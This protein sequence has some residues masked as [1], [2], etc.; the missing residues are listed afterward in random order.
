MKTL[1]GKV[2]VVTGGAGGIGRATALRLAA[3]GCDVAIADVNEAGMDETA[4]EVRAR[5]KRASVHRVDVSKEDEM[6]RLVDDVH[7]AHGRVHVVVNNAGVAVSQTVAEHDLADFEWVV[8]INFWGV[9]YGSKLFLPRLVE[10]GEGHIVNISSVFGLIGLPTQSAYCATKFAVRGF[11][12][13]LRA[14]LVGT[15]VGVTSV[16]PGGVNTDIVKSARFADERARARSVRFFE[17]R[18]VPPS[19]VADGISRAIL[20]DQGRLLVTAETYVVDALKRVAPSLT[21]AV[22]GRFKGLAE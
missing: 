3:D 21:D 8:G 12:E 19:R 4:R 9:V 16:H 10:Q 7:A 11:T 18:T 1:K 22:V 20:R 2:A 17:T 13:A 14:E 15:G 6:A 5:G